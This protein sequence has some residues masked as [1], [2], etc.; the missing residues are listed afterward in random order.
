MS[1]RIFEPAAAA[2]PASSLLQ[3]IWLASPA[4]PVGG[5]SYSYSGRNGT[6]YGPSNT[7]PTAAGDY[8]VTATSSDPNYTGSRTFNYTI[9]KASLT[10]VFSGT[11]NRVWNG[12]AQ[13]LSAST[14]PS[15]TV[16]LTYNGSSNAPANVGRYTVVA[17]VTDANYEGRATN[18][19]TITSPLTLA[20]STNPNAYTLATGPALVDPDL[21]V[22]DSATNTISAARVKIA[23]GLA[24]GDVLSL[25]NYSGPLTASYN[26]TNGVLSLSGSGTA[27][28]YQAALRTVAFNTTN[29]STSNRLL[30]F[31]LGDAVAFNGHLY[32]FVTN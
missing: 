29:S 11:T 25:S 20:T 5:F 9:T 28:Q 16:A 27:A 18:F 15:T 32:R 23:T 12:S 3:L 2:L 22:Q 13:T 19:L 8:T 7:A 1:R 10:P 6:S 17:T 26:P 21:T 24:T 31:A 14:T 4:L 30:T